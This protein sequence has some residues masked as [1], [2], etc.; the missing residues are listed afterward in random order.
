[1]V[2]TSLMDH[3]LQGMNTQ[4]LESQE[5]NVA[6]YIVRKQLVHVTPE[7]I[8]QLYEVLQDDMPGDMR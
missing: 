1:M 4:L 5:R 2:G 6:Q 7:R 8:F 3:V